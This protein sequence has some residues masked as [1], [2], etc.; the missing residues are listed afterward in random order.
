MSLVN[1]HNG[2]FR[3]NLRYN[4][5]QL[6][7]QSLPIKFPAFR[8][9]NVVYHIDPPSPPRK[10]TE[11]S[12]MS[13][14]SLT[15]AWKASEKD[16]G[17]KI[18]EYIVEIKETNQQTWKRCGTT[19][20]DCTNIHIEKLVKDMSYEFRI[21]ARNEA[22]TSSYLE[23]E[24]KIIVGGKISKYTETFVVSFFRVFE[25]EFLFERFVFFFSILFKNN[26]LHALLYYTT[27]YLIKCSNFIQFF[28]MKLLHYFCFTSGWSTEK[29][30]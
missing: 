8:L 27:L 3:L 6:E 11:V 26:F 15:L 7:M 25:R 13:D 21:C 20:G 28:V 22:G 19:N 1:Q 14:S 23:T 2:L 30:K 17:S 24:D 18:I 29:C 12:G 16:G 9:P 5:I 4:N 10:P